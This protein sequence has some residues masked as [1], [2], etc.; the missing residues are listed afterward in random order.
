MEWESNRQK[1]EKAMKKYEKKIETIY[2]RDMEGTKKLKTYGDFV[3]ASS[4]QFNDVQEKIDFIR[5][6]TVH[7]LEK[8]TKWPIVLNI[9]TLQVIVHEGEHFTEDSLPFMAITVGIKCSGEA[10][11]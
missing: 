3:L 5:E 4:D 1:G 7:L 6:A 2:K 9:D 10:K 11:E 8:I